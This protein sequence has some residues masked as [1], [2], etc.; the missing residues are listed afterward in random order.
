MLKRGT[1][2]FRFTYV[3]T[4]LVLFGGISL[5]LY[6]DGLP[7]E[8]Y[9]TQR[10]R[11]LLAGHS[12][13]T[14]PAFMTEENYIAVRA[15]L[16][17]TLQ[18]S[19]FLHEFG[20]IVPLGLYQSVGVTWMG[21]YP[22]GD[23]QETYWNDSTSTIEVRGTTSD[24]QS[25]YMVSYAINPFN[26]F[27]VGANVNVY[28]QTNF[29]NPVYG[30]SVDVAASYR[31]MRHAILGDHI[32]G[33]SAQNVVSPD[34][35]FD[36]F[37][38][39][40]VN[41]KASWL[42]KFWEK[43]I[44]AGIDIDLKDFMSKAE[45][46]A[47]TAAS[48]DVPKE[49]EFD[50]NFRLGVWVLNMINAYFQVGSDYIGISGGM[51]VPTINKGRDFQIAYQYMNITDREDITSSHTAYFRG[52]FGKHREEVY[53]RRMARL[54]SIGPGNLYNKAMTLYTQGNYYDAFFIYGKILV[55]Y[56]DF[57]KNDWVQ[58][59]LSSCQE[60]LDMRE[61]SF[62]NYEKAKRNYPR[63]VIMPYADLGLM[64][65][66]YRNGNSAGVANQF[67]KLNAPSV[68]DSLKFHA[69]YY[70]GQM[71][72]KDGEYD[73]AIQLFKLIPESHGEYIFAQHSLAVAYA[74]SDNLSLAISALDN[75]IQ[76]TP[77]TKAQQETVN[78]S[79]IFLGYIFYEGLG[80]QK[81]AL[82]KAVSALR[83]VSATSY[84]YEDA[85]LGLAWCGLTAS[86]WSDCLNACTTLKTTSKKPI[87][88]LEAM[89]LE[90]YVNLVN[91]K[92]VEAVTI[93]RKA[94]SQINAL[95]APSDNEQSAA[96][97]EYDNNRS[98]YYEIASEANG[99]ALTSQSSFVLAQIDSLRAP[100]TEYQKKLTDYYI[101]NDEFARRSFFS[102]N[103]DKVREDVIYA[104]AKAE[105]LAGQKAIDRTLEKAAK[106]TEQI[107][108]EMQRLEQELKE[109]EKQQTEE[110][111]KEE[112]E[113]PKEEETPE[114]Q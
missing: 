14:N 63:S 98:I 94:E 57:F 18:N 58:L 52:D 113:A 88:Q 96:T 13:T 25:L 10:W 101:F 104:L 54:A 23:L 108:D 66:H 97:L 49:I 20:A 100:Q 112:D 80:G 107:D 29:N 30:I 43:R 53:A 50:F 44:D 89:L 110:P 16:C 71:N 75:V 7:G 56:P 37:Q 76:M 3:V 8:Y 1:P 69:Y 99:L 48:G 90:A 22:N 68:P 4:F 60:E 45:D 111:A 32:V 28:H 102:R 40:S 17:P 31:F 36:K 27:S 33:I 78:R 62:E 46:F 73:K 103:I 21:L 2:F 47:T 9:V 77:K 109:L 41:L 15:A 35:D 114:E 82:S 84:Y 12:P 55:E 93:L 42:A 95:T 65:L 79:F 19:F 106:Q 61:F 64:R 59:Y 70:Q 67:A 38:N 83:K 74:L 85:L 26:R 72:I 11:D 105:K 39:Y 24:N 91:K 86:Q 34:L 92:N 5:P 81:R 87:I 6:A 51:N